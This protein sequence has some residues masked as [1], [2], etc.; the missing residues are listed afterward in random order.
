MDLRSMSAV[1][2][3]TAALLICSAANLRAKETA[4]SY[5]K[6]GNENYNKHDLIAAIADYTRAIDANPKYKQAYYK[7]G[8]VK[9]AEGDRNGAIADYTRAIELDPKYADVY[10]ERADVWSKNRQYDSAIKDIQTA[11]EL[12]PKNGDNYLSLGWYELFNRDP[13]G[14][15]A[16]SLKG[17]ERSPDKAALIKTN[18]AHGY[19]FDNQ[20][21]KAKAI[22]L[23]NRDAKLRDD[24]RTFGEAVL[25][26]FRELEE[27]GITHPDMEK[28]KALMQIKYP[29]PNGRFAL[30]RTDGD[31]QLI[32]NDS[33]NVIVDLGEPWRRQV[34]VWSADSKWAAYGNRGD[35]AGELKVYFWNGS[36]F[37]EVTLPDDLPSP[38]MPFRK[39]C[40]SVKN[41]GGAVTPLRWRKPGALEL[42]SDLMMLCRDS[43]DT[44]TSEIRFTLAFDAQHHASVKNVGKTKIE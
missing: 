33:G 39:D 40:G 8:L 34:L 26:D 27:A 43:G 2:A 36:A 7:R 28:I 37:Q 23:E 29:S 42:S 20:F 15:I 41:Y 10:R 4:E 9:D 17:L 13:R 21:D 25:D 5:Y 35:K 31:V 1:L 3:M 14:A 32:E 19:L 44:Y 12:E 24:E 6:R 38:G 18:L 30:R 11:I 16:V 22:Y